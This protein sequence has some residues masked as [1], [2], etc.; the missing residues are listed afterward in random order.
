VLCR[1]LG[2]ANRSIRDDRERLETSRSQASKHT[3]LPSGTGQ[4]ATCFKHLDQSCSLRR[5]VSS[6]STDDLDVPPVESLA[7][8]EQTKKTFERLENEAAVS[9]S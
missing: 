4:H 7:F 8:I 5:N 1:S 9:T 6:S 2:V 3:S